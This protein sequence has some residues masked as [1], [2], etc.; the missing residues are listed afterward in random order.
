MTNLPNT[1]DNR[2]GLFFV[3]QGGL[4]TREPSEITEKVPLKR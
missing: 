4:H 3:V 2:V 1:L